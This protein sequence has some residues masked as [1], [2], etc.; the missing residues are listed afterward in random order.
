GAQ[1]MIGRTFGPSDPAEVVVISAGLWQR[2]FSGDRSLVGK[3]ITLDGRTFTIIGVMPEV[4]QFP[5][6]SAAQN[7]SQLP[8]R[9]DVWVPSP[10]LR[11]ASGALRRGRNTV[12][13]RLKSD[14]TL[15]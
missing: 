12:I 10:G 13:A 6:G 11:D 15:D 1:A 3:P 4:F 7:S 9:T 8:A 5:Y 2:R 14:V